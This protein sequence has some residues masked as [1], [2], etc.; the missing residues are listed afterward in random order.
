M[1]IDTENWGYVWGRPVLNI[2]SSGR[3]I[4]SGFYFRLFCCGFYTQHYDKWLAI[5]QN[6]PNTWLFMNVAQQMLNVPRNLVH[7]IVCP[8][9]DLYGFWGGAFK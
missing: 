2:R 8:H 5:H 4:E 6:V 9:S 1:G 7:F 3:R